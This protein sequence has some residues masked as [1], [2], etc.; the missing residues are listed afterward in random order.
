MEPV[1]R[2]QPKPKAVDRGLVTARFTAG[3]PIISLIVVAAL[4]DENAEVTTAEFSSGQVAVVRY[5]L[6]NAP[7]VRWVVVRP[8]F[9]LAY[10][11]ELNSLRE[12]TDG[13]L[14]GWY[15]EV[16]PGGQGG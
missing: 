9:H 4:A 16:P 15:E 3:E 8:G 1:K 10:S 13:T 6:N 5:R 2:W 7:E 12:T 11:R 14:D